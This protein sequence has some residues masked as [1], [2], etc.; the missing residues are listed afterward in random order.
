MKKIA[1]AAIIGTMLFSCSK[2]EVQSL[3]KEND[4]LPIDAGRIDEGCVPTTKTVALLAGQTMNAGEVTVTNDGVDLTVTYN[5]LN[6]WKISEIHLYVGEFASAPQNN[7]GNPIPGRF[8]IK[9]TFS[10]GVTTYSKVI[11]LA[12]LPDCFI[13]A[14]HAVVKS[15]TGTT[16]G[17]QTGWGQG[18]QFPG[19]NWGM[20]FD[21]CVTTCP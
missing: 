11:P 20:Y 5:C 13:V 21:Y 15:G 3:V 19:N 2:T 14:A 10:T 16:G 6:G 17:T 18:T 1:F 9:E 12:S 8:P 7:G 4:V